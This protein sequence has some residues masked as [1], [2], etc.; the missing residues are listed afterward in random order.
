MALPTMTPDPLAEIQADQRRAGERVH[1]PAPPQS[2]L[3]LAAQA[4]RAFGVDLPA[5]YLAFLA[6][7]DGLDYNGLVVYDSLSSP[8]Q[9]SEGFWQG[10]V[11]ANQAWRQNPALAD[12]LVFGDSD[13]DLLA[14]H[15]PSGRFRRV[16]RVALDRFDDYASFDE[17][18]DAA[19]R[20]RL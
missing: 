15:L 1:P 14:W 19:L 5:A 2:C 16:D 11:A 10:F 3:A 7:S 4:R 18:L 6:R 20:E 17:M 8:E 12:W 13:M 9:P